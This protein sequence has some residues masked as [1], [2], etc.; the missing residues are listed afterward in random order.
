MKEQQALLAMTLVA[1]RAAMWAH[2]VLSSH[3]INEGEISDDAASRF[4]SD[5]MEALAILDRKEGG[6]R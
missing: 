3:S 1:R 5:I 2:D 4:K 6:I